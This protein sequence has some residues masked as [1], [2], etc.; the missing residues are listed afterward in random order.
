MERGD[1][2]SIGCT[3]QPPIGRRSFG[4]LCAGGLAAPFV[5]T[6]PRAQSAIL[7]EPNDK[8]G[9]HD[10]FAQL[11][12]HRWFVADY[13]FQHPHFDTDWKK[14]NVTHLAETQAII[15]RLSPKSNG[16]EIGQRNRYWGGSM[17]RRKTS[18][19]GRY[20]AML[21]PAKG[22]GMVTGFFT[23]TGPYYGT[24]HDEI[25]IEFLGRNTG[26]MQV[27]WFVDGQLRS[28]QIELGFDASD[29]PRRYAFEW[30]P[31][32]LRWF[33]EGELV[34]EVDRTSAPLPEVP[35]Y[36]YLNLWAAAPALEK[37]AGRTSPRT[38]GRAQIEDVR[39]TPL[40][41]L[42]LGV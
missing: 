22:D 8:R 12:P 37:W 5:S 23:Y 10:P 41:E 21:Q 29:R 27:S 3:L 24:R 15:L 9:F 4:K 2:H 31:E 26:M 16:G 20:E 25:D 7:P 19:F 11:S 1:K 40:S 28:R 42:I 32:R 6:A 39:F 34:F 17:R 30:W 36:L 33:V 35:G 13:A 38:R 14:S 18:G